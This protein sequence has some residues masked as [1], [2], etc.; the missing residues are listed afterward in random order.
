MVEAVDREW[1]RLVLFVDAEHPPPLL[2]RAHKVILTAEEREA[3][4]LRSCGRSIVSILQTAVVPERD[5]F[6]TIYVSLTP[7]NARCSQEA[8]GCT[9]SRTLDCGRRG[10]PMSPHA[11]LRRCCG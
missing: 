10:F 6:A 5:P 7:P 8:L 3:A 4:V 1:L 9:A 11:W 2:A